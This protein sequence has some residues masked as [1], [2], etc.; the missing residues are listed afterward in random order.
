MKISKKRLK[1]IIKEEYL[2]EFISTTTLGNNIL[3]ALPDYG[4]QH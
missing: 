3:K 1:E 2:K 4:V